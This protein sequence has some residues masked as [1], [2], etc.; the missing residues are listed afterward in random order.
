M[1]LIRGRLP[2]DQRD[3]IIMVPA[4]QIGDKIHHVVHDLAPHA[5]VMESLQQRGHIGFGDVLDGQ[6]N[7]PWAPEQDTRLVMVDRLKKFFG[8]QDLLNAALLGCLLHP[9]AAHGL[10]G[11]GSSGS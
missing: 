9:A 1:L 8:L 3:Q 10:D 4:L 2:M 6:R 11:G 7:I 5:D